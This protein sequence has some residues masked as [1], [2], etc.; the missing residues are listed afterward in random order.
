M[1]PALGRSHGRHR[2]TLLTVTG[3]VSRPPQGRTRWPLT[4][5][6]IG[7]GSQLNVAAL[8]LPGDPLA[9]LSPGERV[10]TIAIDLG[11]RRRLRVNGVVADVSSR[12]FT[13]VVDEAFGNC[14]QYIQQR[15][16]SEVNGQDAG[17]S[18]ARTTAGP[19]ELTPAIVDRI[20]AA[21]TF[22]LGSGHPVRGG[23]CSH[24]GGSPGFVCVEDGSLWWPDYSGNNMFTSFGNLAVNPA[25][26]LLF[27]DFDARSTIHLSGTA[28]VDF[29]EG[30]SSGDDDGTGRR[31]RFDP[32]RTVVVERP[33]LESTPVIPYSRNPIVST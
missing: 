20:R 22:F 5:F 27:F 2:A 17:R 31:V 12:G 4:G 3:Q 21:D 16:V 8:P 11:T 23:D 33:G 10:G 32:R 26:A 25:A 19:S 1:W 29:D 15:E 6:L 24:R 30:G 7:S 13:I 28:R 9:Q 18:T 14:P